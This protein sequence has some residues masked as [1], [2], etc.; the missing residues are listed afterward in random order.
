MKKVF[1]CTLAHLV[2]IYSFVISQNVGIGTT[3]PSEKLEVNGIVYSNLG[4]IKFPDNTIQTTA[5]FASNT[6]N[7]AE[8]R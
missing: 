6:E 4:G 3:N 1:L 8:T 7:A 5:A 2:C